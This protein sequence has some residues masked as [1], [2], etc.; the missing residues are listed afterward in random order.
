MFLVK[1][2]PPKSGKFG[3]FFPLKILCIG[4]HHIFSGQNLVKFCPIKNTPERR[5][6]K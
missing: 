5:G 1:N 4:R 2:I 3:P 6:K